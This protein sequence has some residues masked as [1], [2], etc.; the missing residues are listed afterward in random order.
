MISYDIIWYDIIQRVEY[1]Y[2]LN[3]IDNMVIYRLTILTIT[4]TT[5]AN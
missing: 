5:N 4:N 1:K 2:D 3:H